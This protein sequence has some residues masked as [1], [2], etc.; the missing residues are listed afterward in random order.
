MVPLTGLSTLSK[1]STA[2][3]GLAG[4]GPLFL[5]ASGRSGT[6][7]KLL[8]IRTW[9]NLLQHPVRDQRDGSELAWGAP[10]PSLER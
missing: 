4:A 2:L 6:V 7:R 3:R 10:K 1:V 9:I 8:E 5:V